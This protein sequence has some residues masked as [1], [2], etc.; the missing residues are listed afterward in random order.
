LANGGPPPNDVTISH[1]VTDGSLG[2]AS[3]VGDVAGTLPGAVTLG[4]TGP[5]NRYT[6]N[7][8]FGQSITFQ[9][10]PTANSA[11]PPFLQDT[12]SVFLV[13]PA[14][15]L[16]ILPTSDPTGANA[17]FRIGIGEPIRG[18]IYVVNMVTL[19]SPA[20]VPTPDSLLL[21]AS[22]ILILAMHSGRRCP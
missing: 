6:Q 2:A 16:S 14:T 17:L 15:G 1:F 13:D 3:R 8:T 4:D 18:S 9:F 5:R 10:E 21:A 11:T 19:T 7:L 12:F 20:P 22:A